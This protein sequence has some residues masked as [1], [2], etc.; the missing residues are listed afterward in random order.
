MMYH[1]D[2]HI[3]SALS[4]CA[5]CLMTPHNIFNMAMLKGLD[6]IAVTDHNSLKQIQICHEIS[7]SYDMLFIP[8]VEITVQE[9]FDL[10]IYFKHIEEALQ[11]DHII[12]HRLPHQKNDPDYYGEQHIFNVYDDVI[13]M[14]PYLL[15]QPLQLSI[16]ELNALLEP[17]DCIIVI[18]HIDRYITLINQYI[19]D[20]HFHALETKDNHNPYLILNN[21]DAHQLTDIS[22]ST[23]KNEINLS[24]LTIDAFFDYFKHE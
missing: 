7:K 22:E 12:E 18:A 9:G 8:A 20:V 16:Y 14:Y 13:D 4:P 19:N 23:T 24:T 1:Y 2:L 11:F 6:I 15:I 21:S 10:L 3:H 5:D 17:F